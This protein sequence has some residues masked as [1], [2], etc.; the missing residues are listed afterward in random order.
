[1]IKKIADNVWKIYYGNFGSNCYFIKTIGKNILIDT[2][3]EENKQ[4]LISDLNKIKIKPA[5]IGIV[6]L[7]H[8]HY[9][10]VGNI[11]LFENARIYASEQEIS[12]FKEQPLGT[13]LNEN[14]IEKVVDGEGKTKPTYEFIKVGGIKIES[15]ENFKIKSIKI[16][17]LPGH[18]RGS[19]G[20]Y[21]PKEKILFSGDTLFDEGIGRTDLPTSNANEMGD[22]LEKL[23]NLD[24]EILCAGH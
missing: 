21:M 2:S 19:L 11:E 8:L 17:Q 20:F 23:K 4:E 3:G 14:F 15:I 16:M 1:M 22:S 5:E 12:D 6:L 24:Y 7:T 9:D 18:T 13:V 10:H